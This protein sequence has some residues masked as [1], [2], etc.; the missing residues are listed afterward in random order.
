MRSAG[1]P[2]FS[3]GGLAVR[4]P[5]IARALVAG[6]WALAA[7]AGDV[8][9][10]EVVLAPTDA[11]ACLSPAEAKRERPV[12]PAEEL[13]LKDGHTVHA[14]FVFDAPDSRPAVEILDGNSVGPYEN[15]VR[16]YARQLR[17]PCMKP[18]AAPVHLRQDFVF[19]PNDGRKV[20]WTAAT[21]AADAHRRELLK[22]GTWPKGRDG[23]IRYPTSA[24]QE[25]LQGIVVVKLRFV[26]P[27]AAPELTII[28]DAGSGAFVN[29]LRPYVEQMRVPC[30]QQEP[31]EF[32]MFFK[33][34]IPGR[35]E[36]KLVLKDLD[37][38]TYLGI[39]SSAPPAYF[40]TSTM[41]CP[42][43][44]RLKFRQPFEPN[45]IAELEQDVPARHAFLDW[46]AALKLDIE[47][48]RAKQL[49][50]QVS[51]IHVP[52]VKLDI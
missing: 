50:G 27:A 26:D 3:T 15:A 24:L 49:F 9:G 1:W 8:R 16:D 46:L 36:S 12:Y 30:L 7:L 38:Q 47:P 22:C 10:Q 35:G 20:V 13:R 5:A 45:G 33:F 18:G 6:A 44:V 43:D 52:C 32:H 39:V 41:G 28:D 29:A 48:A 17:V 2:I 21:D 34:Q 23:Y 37:L 14:E 4:L 25:R 19:E 11:Q 51:T 40:D 42:F 31:V